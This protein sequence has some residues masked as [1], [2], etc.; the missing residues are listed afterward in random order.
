[1][2]AKIPS[3]ITDTRNVSGLLQNIYGRAP[4]AGAVCGIYF[5]ENRAALWEFRESELA[6]T[7]PTACET[8]EFWPEVYEVVSP[9]HPEHGPITE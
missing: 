8:S 4:E 5:F 6:K 2:K 3:P 7:V 1:M 9:Q